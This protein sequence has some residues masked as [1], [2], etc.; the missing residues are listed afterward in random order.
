MD[1]SP[2]PIRAKASDLKVKESKGTI[3]FDRE[4]GRV[5]ESK[6]TLQITGTITFTLNNNELPPSDLDLKM[7]STITIGR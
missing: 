5:V 2:L 3:L 6:E 7:E 4:L 1:D